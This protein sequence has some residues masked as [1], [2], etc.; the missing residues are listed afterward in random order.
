MI[1]VDIAQRMREM[2]VAYVASPR[3]TVTSKAGLQALLRRGLKAD[4]VFASWVLQ[5]FLEVE[6]DVALI[7]GAMSPMARAS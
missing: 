2:A 1:G 6:Q 3:F 5:H 4:F 7:A